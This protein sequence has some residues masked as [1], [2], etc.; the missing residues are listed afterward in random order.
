MITEELCEVFG[1]VILFARNADH[2]TTE[3]VVNVEDHVK[4]FALWQRANKVH[5]DDFKG[6]RGDF[7]RLKRCVW[8]LLWFLQE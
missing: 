4:T 8:A 5:R 7:V 3:V 2:T 6:A 1:V